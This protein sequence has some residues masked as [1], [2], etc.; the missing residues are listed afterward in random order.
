MGRQKSTEHVASLYFLTALPDQMLLPKVGLR[1]KTS[2]D[3]A[4]ENGGH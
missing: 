3:R 1:Y 2:K 4:E